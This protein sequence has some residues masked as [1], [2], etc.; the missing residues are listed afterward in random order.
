[1]L[2]TASFTK[3]SPEKY[4][5]EQKKCKQR[6]D[7]N[8]KVT[9]K[10]RKKGYTFLPRSSTT[11]PGDHHEGC[12]SLF[13]THGE[14]LHLVIQSLSRVPPACCDDSASPD[15]DRVDLVLQGNI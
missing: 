15:S 13:T 12:K 2:E 14:E 10:L 11:C 7:T 9:N 8:I 3:K 4:L 6:N 5:I 1:M